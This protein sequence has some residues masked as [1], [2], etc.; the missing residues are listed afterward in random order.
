MSQ[1][2]TVVLGAAEARLR[3]VMLALPDVTEEFPWGH[4]TA[5]VRGKMFAILVLDEEGLRVTTK[6]PT[7]NEAAL[8]L[9]FAEPT[10][11]GLGKSG[12][13]T[14]RFSPGQEVP[15]EL[16]ALWIQES[17]RAVAPK[18]LGDGASVVK[19]S[20]ASKTKAVGAESTASGE[21]SSGTKVKPA[22]AKPKTA[23]VKVTATDAKLKPAAAKPKTVSAKS[24][25]TGV[26]AKAVGVK[27]APAGAKTSGAQVKR[28]GKKVAAAAGKPSARKVAPGVKR[29]RTARRATASRSMQS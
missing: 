21:K 3:E 1:G 17:F 10:G 26:E 27:A 7:S 16:M 19:K 6:L 4:R 8:M 28:P 11:Y 14:A 15:V 25:S 23:S 12:W 9:P 22:A 24:K 5:K 2:A 13:V 29:P 18:S 20:A